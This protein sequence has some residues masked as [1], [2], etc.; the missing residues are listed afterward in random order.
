MLILTKSIGIEEVH[1]ND[2]N[3]LEIVQSGIM[4]AISKPYANLT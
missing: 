1:K 2:E 4:E 3:S